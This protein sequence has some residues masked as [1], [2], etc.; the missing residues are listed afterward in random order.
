M[1]GDIKDKS[2]NAA[3]IQHLEQLLA[4]AKSGALRSVV[5]FCGWDDDSVSHG[6]SLDKR[7]SQR[8]MLAEMVLLQ[9]DFTV[10]L[11]LMDEDSILSDALNKY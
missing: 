10:N 11:S 8:R 6:W 5:A 1:I 3:T 7:N 9:H 2:P 4:E